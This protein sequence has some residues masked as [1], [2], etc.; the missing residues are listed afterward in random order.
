M[1]ERS[2]ALAARAGR[3][4][5]VGAA[6]AGLNVAIVWV[7]HDLLGAP[8]LM[9]ALATCVVTIP[10]SYLTHRRFSFV[11][12]GPAGG[13]EFARFVLQQLSQFALGLVL[14]VLLVETLGLPPAPGMAVVAALMFAYGF[15]ING[16]CVFRVFGRR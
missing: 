16:R 8:Y 14:L 15:L 13:V 1:A 11:V 4:A 5:L 2:A 12:S 9:A 7:G 10:L 6:C 3:Y